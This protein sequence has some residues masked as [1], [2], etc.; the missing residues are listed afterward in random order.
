MI[1]SPLPLQTAEI[2]VGGGGGGYGSFL[3]RPN[4]VAKRQDGVVTPPMGNDPKYN[5]SND[6]ESKEKSYWGY[7]FQKNC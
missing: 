1:F 3:E 7:M 6:P 4:S 2:L 5:S